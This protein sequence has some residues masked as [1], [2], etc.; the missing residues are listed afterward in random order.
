VIPPGRTTPPAWVERLQAL[1][2]PVFGSRRVVR[3]RAV[4]DRYNAGG[5]GLLA[6]GIAYNTLF[7]L[8]P[9]ALFA[10]GLLGLIVTD[11]GIHASVRDLLTDWAP[12]LSAVVDE[13]LVGLA[14]VSPSLS[15][16]GLLGLAWGS[17]RLFA[18]L[19]MGIEAM[20]AD[21]ARRGLVSRTL[22]RIGSIVVVAG[23]VAIALVAISLAS[24]V[25][26]L[27]VA[28]GDVAA[29]IVS[30]G[31]LAL[32]VI[33][34]AVALATMYRVLPPVRPDLEAIVRPTLVIALALVVATRLFAELAPRLLGANFVYGTLGAL[35]VALAWLGLTYSLVLLGAAWVRERMLADEG[36]ATVA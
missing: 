22:R 14:D 33:V 1:A 9:L 18:S 29:Y 19:E 34:T 24:V 12:P 6:A 25:A 30:I 21:V 16:I 31:V 17:T 11:P 27:L 20:F 3:A 7:A 10:S 2:L 23:V 13:L 5:G 8:L 4:I 28:G 15:L 36:P 32:P 26:E 35:F